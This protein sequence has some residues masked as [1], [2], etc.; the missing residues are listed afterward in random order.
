MSTAARALATNSS[1]SS[2]D[3]EPARKGAAPR[4]RE[5]ASRSLYGPLG[6]NSRPG[7]AGSGT[8]PEQLSPGWSACFISVMQLVA[9]RRKIALPADVAV[10]A[11]VDLGRAG[12][13]YEL[14]AGLDLSLPGVE[15][16]AVERLIEAAHQIARIPAPRRATSAL[17]SDWFEA[18]RSQA[19]HE[20]WSSPQFNQ[21]AMPCLSYR[22]S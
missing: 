17:R 20:R 6:V 7:G 13:A 2:A 9:G 15:R 11:K 5:G 18:E 8:N 3:H 22:Y 4:G 16:D 21:S 14:A 19:R 12:D 1:Q 10:D